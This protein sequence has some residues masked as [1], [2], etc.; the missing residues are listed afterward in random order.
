MAESI[1]SVENPI[2]IHY[3]LFRGGVS[4]LMLSGLDIL[5][6]KGLIKKGITIAVGTADRSEWF[7]DALK[8]VAPEGFQVNLA[9][10]PE[11]AYWSDSALSTDEAAERIKKAL[12]SLSHKN[13]LLWAHNPTLGKNP[14][15][16]RAMRLIASQEPQRPIFMHVH[17]S[18]EQG[19]WPN[20]G[21]MRSELPETPYFISQ[22]TRW[23]TINKTDESFFSHAGMPNG[24]LNYFPDIISKKNVSAN[25]NK[26]QI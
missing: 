18:A 11:L 10:I 6:N 9:V 14:A 7:T 13:A 2:V 5:I 26:A 1:T 4:Q 19:R 20:L 12:T 24:Y 22:N 8:R 15:Y 23:L 25:C 16:A 3:H 21:L 17:D